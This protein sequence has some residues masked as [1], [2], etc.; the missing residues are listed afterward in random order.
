MSCFD[1]LF[2]NGNILTMHRPQR[3]SE[4]A[5]SAGKVVAVGEP[6]ELRSQAS[7]TTEVVDLEGLTLIPGFEDAHAHVWKMGQLL[8]T[9]LD[10][11]RSA[12][13]ESMGAQLSQRHA[14]LPKG[15]WLLGRGFNEIVLAERRRPTRDDLD[16]FVAD[17]PVVLTRTCGHIFVANSLALRLAGIDRATAA[18]Q[19]GIIERGEDGEPNGLLHETAMGLIHRVLP[20]PSRAD[21]K[22]MIR[23][24]LNH[25]LSLGITS[26]SDCGVLPDLLEAY[27]EMDGDGALPARMAVMPLG[28]PDGSTGPMPL[29]RLHSSPMLRVDTVKFLA[30]GGLSGAT[31]AL[32]VPYRE[33]N[34]SGVVRFRSEDLLALFAQARRAGWRIATHAIGDAAIEQVLGL[35]EQLGPQPPGSPHRIEHVGLPSA[36]QLKR[37]AALGIVAVTQPIFLNELGANFLAV[38]PDRLASRIYPFQDMLQAGLPVAFSSDAPVVENDCPLAGI[39][40]AITRRSREGKTILA[41]QAISAEQALY[42]YTRAAA[43]AAGEESLRGSIQ[44]GRW[45][46]FALLSADPTAVEPEAIPGIQVQ[47]T[48]LGGKPAYERN[49]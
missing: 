11:R 49:S 22:E 9:S 42:A 41:E 40:A 24:A 34:S 29:P 17:R 44:A 21:Y 7:P 37:M 18:P 27:L 26:S 47:R 46:D 13:I 35:Y 20:P 10:L 19:G 48:Y 25:Q 31:A 1:R 36:P 15:A 5:V 14:I 39:H 4:V 38:V 8:T 33:S 6:G 45:A 12:S 2:V 43:V 30:D 3:A 28:R 16:R 23:S 32:S